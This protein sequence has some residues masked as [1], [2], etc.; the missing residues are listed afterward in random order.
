MWTVRI[1]LFFFFGE[2]MQKLCFFL[3]IEKEKTHKSIIYMVYHKNNRPVKQNK[4]LLSE[5]D[6]LCDFGGSCLDPRLCFFLNLSDDHG[7][8]GSY[9]PEDIGIALALE[10]PSR[11]V[12]LGMWGMRDGLYH[13]SST[14]VQSTFMNLEV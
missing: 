3:L 11:K 8:C 9:V 5:G 1:F 6:D 4:R 13:Q 2:G 10:P 7:C 14:F 12:F